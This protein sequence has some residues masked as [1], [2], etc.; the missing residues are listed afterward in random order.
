MNELLDVK[1]IEVVLSSS[2]W[3]NPLLGNS[4]L[5]GIAAIRAIF[6][7]YIFFYIIQLCMFVLGFHS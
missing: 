4:L 6:C 1:L 3:E 2:V 7:V 5:V